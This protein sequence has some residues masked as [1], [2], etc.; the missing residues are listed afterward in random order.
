MNYKIE[1][2]LPV[3]CRIVEV[4]QRMN[5]KQK[6]T[7]SQ[8]TNISIKKFAKYH[9]HLQNTPQIL[10][11]EFNELN[12]ISSKFNISDNIGKRFDNYRKNRYLNIIPCKFYGK[13]KLL[14]HARSRGEGGLNW[15]PF[16]TAS[17]TVSL[18]KI[19]K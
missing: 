1:N 12:E 2:T 17:W 11:I 6:L 4:R 9:A 19:K 7:V 15:A 13:G 3:L 8:T 18:S 14:S 5:G 10:K 16:L